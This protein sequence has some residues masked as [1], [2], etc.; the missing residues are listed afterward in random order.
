M[1]DTLKDQWGPYARLVPFETVAQQIEFARSCLPE[2]VRFLVPSLSLAKDGPV[3]ETVFLITEKYLCEVRLK[4]NANDFDV[5]LLAT[6]GNYRVE[7]DKQEITH[8]E[9]ASEKDAATESQVTKIT[10]DTA[11]IRF[12]HTVNVATD[13]TYVGEGRDDWIQQVFTAFP[14]DLL[15]KSRRERT[16]PSV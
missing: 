1:P 2:E 11:K 6:I 3:V 13:L 5:S 12:V 4:E 15:F 8:E 9:A 14:I 10:Y 16:N 7:T